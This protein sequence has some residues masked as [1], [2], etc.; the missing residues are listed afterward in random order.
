MNWPQVLGG[1]VRRE[2]QSNEATAWAMEQ[3]LGGDATPA[4]LAAFVIALRSKGET[5]EELSGLAETMIDFA[6]PIEIGGTAVDVVGSG[7]DRSNTV[8]ISTMAAIVAAAAG[9]RVVKH[10]NRAASSACGAADVLEALGLVLDLT[11]EAQ[12]RG[13]RAGRHRL[14]VRQAVPPGAAARRRCAKRARHPHHLQLPRPA[15]Q[16]G[17]ADRP[18]GRR[19]RRP[20]GRS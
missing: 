19:R 3:I 9:A 4:Q 13:G 1:L 10:G 12:Q 18:G 15:G 5:V 11:P 7:G 6:T 14:P 17:A 16:P 20:D 2:D 8:N